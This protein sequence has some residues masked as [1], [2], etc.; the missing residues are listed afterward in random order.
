[1]PEVLF[2]TPKDGTLKLEL[3]K[4]YNVSYKN[5]VNVGNATCIIHGKGAYKGRKMVTFIIAR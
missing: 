4:D 3:G 2:V 1:V 5:N